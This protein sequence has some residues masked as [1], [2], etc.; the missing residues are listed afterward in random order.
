MLQITCV[1]LINSLPAD[2]ICDSFDLVVV[3][4]NRD[5]QTLR[6]ACGAQK[7]FS[8]LRNAQEVCGP[9]GLWTHDGEMSQR[10]LNP[11]WEFQQR[12]VGPCQRMAHVVCGPCY[13]LS[14]HYVGPFWLDSGYVY[15]F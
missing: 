14:Q 7:A 3:Q 12:C 4:W 13:G 9:R 6:R 15:I 8:M 2:I 11:C 10:C 1:P 5:T